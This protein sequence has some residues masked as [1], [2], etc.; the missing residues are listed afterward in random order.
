MMKLSLVVNKQVYSYQDMRDD[1]TV[2]EML[3]IYFGILKSASYNF[4]VDDF[5][6]VINEREYDGS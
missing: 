1:H 2:D 6:C 3:E 4:K 5:L